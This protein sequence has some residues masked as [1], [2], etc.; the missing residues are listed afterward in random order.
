LRS[1]ES[2]ACFPSR[3][4]GEEDGGSAASI[5]LGSNAQGPETNL[6]SQGSGLAPC[7][8]TGPSPGI[9][10]GCD[11]TEDLLLTWIARPGGDRNGQQR[12]NNHS[13]GFLEH[14]AT[15]INGNLVALL[16]H[17]V[18]W[19]VLR[20]RPRRNT[21]SLRRSR[22]S[23]DGLASLLDIR[24]R[25]QECHNLARHALS[26]L[27]VE[28][29]SLEGARDAAKNCALVAALAQPQVPA[30]RAQCYLTRGWT[31][32]AKG[33]TQAS[34]HLGIWLALGHTVYHGP[35]RRCVKPE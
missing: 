33:A 19:R 7:K 14:R 9:N 21:A 3:G 15:R 10:K 27:P 32:S 6:S 25:E 11:A 16:L 5:A 17:R 18:E 24:F 35:V 1:P 30:C 2:S 20:L 23:Y 28:E 4:L 31:L 8:P 13:P 26:R 34:L 22:A 12:A 29:R